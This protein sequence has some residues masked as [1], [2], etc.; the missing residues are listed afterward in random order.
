MP[1]EPVVE[2]PPSAEENNTARR[3][4]ILAKSA[5]ALKASIAKVNE[6]PLTNPKGARAA[7]PAPRPEAPDEP[8]APE[9]QEAAPEAPAA[10]Q[11]AESLTKSKPE[12]RANEAR[13]KKDS[14]FV[15][16]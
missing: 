5:A 15:S 1:D 13:P 6:D 7:A 14:R 4:A 8:E 11:A 2:A 3:D 10:P 16:R 9:G 12:T